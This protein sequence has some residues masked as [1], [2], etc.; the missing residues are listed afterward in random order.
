MILH[1]SEQKAD[2]WEAFFNLY[3]WRME[4]MALTAV[5][6][7]TVT[8]P[9]GVTLSPATA[10]ALQAGQVKSAITLAWFGTLEG[11]VGLFCFVIASV[12]ALDLWLQTSK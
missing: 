10:A 3:F 5:S 12:I 11:F 7:V 4:H 1:I 8:T 6:V 9:M 2:H